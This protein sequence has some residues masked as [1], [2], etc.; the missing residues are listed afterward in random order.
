MVTRQRVRSGAIDT[1]FRGVRMAALLLAVAALALAPA[2]QRTLEATPSRFSQAIVCLSGGDRP[3]LSSV[4]RPRLEEY[5]HRTGSAL[6]VIHANSADGLARLL[7][8]PDAM[9]QAWSQTPVSGRGNNTAYVL[10]LLAAYDALRVYE[11]VLLVD[12]TV[13]V[14]SNASNV[15]EHCDPA[16][17]LCAYGEGAETTCPISQR[18]WNDSRDWLDE[19]HG[20]RALPHEHVNGGVLLFS[21][22]TPQAAAAIEML[23]SPTSLTAGIAD[24]LF[25][26]FF[27]EQDYLVG[28]LAQ[29]RS[30]A[31]PNEPDAASQELHKLLPMAFNTMLIC[32][33]RPDEAASHAWTLSAKEAVAILRDD[34]VAFIHLVSLY[35]QAVSMQTLADAARG[36]ADDDD[37][38]PDTDALD[39]VALADLLNDLNPHATQPPPRA[40]TRQPRYRPRR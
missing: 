40:A 25:S 24:G 36:M 29:A 1:L 26:G 39:L 22:A 31:H 19:Q 4:V 7:H 38:E 9:R 28:R 34:A 12:D 18:T 17:P 14:K 11:R 20:I 35:D 27:S 30:A 8:V 15:F 16:M 10:K 37:D 2:P 32:H 33:R 5:A 23:L 13:F 3:W 21:R 6:R